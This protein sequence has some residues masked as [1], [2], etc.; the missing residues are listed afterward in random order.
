MRSQIVRIVVVSLML[1]ASHPSAAG[2]AQTNSL[3][4]ET[5][6]AS[7]QGASTPGPQPAASSESRW[8]LGIALGSGLRTNPL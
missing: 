5:S 2:E 3:A 7:A 1:L 8:Q 6:A 4:D